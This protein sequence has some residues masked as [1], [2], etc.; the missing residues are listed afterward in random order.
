M[1]FS[2]VLLKQ[3]RQLRKMF[4]CFLFFSNFLPLAS[5]CY[6]SLCYPFLGFAIKPQSLTVLVFKKCC[7]V[8]YQNRVAS[9][10]MQLY[11]EKLA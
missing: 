1:A 8:D 4:F 10:S 7:N 3:K 11:K 2:L 9:F 6:T 5:G